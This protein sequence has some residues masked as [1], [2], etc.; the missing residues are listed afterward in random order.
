MRLREILISAQSFGYGPA[1]KAVAIASQ[2]RKSAS[3]VKLTFLGNRNA[4]H[5]AEC[6]MSVFD[7]II[8]TKNPREIGT[9]LDR[10]NYAQIISVMEPYTSVLGRNRYIPIAYV[11]SLYFF[12]K[13]KS[14]LSTGEITNIRRLLP[15]NDE[16]CLK[17]LA[18]LNSHEMQLAG[19][20]AADQSFIQ[21]YPGFVRNDISPD[22]IGTLV[23]VNPILEDSTDDFADKDT[24]LVSLCGQISPAIDLEKAL[25]YAK[26]CLKLITPCVT[27]LPHGITTVIVGNPDVIRHLR[28]YT[29]IETTNLSHQQYMNRLK[30]SVGLLAPVSLTSLYES[31]SSQ[32]PVFFLPEQHDGHAPNYINLCHHGKSVSYVEKTFPGALLFKRFPELQDIA[33]NGVGTIYSIIRELETWD[34]YRYFDEGMKSLNTALESFCHEENSRL[35]AHAQRE[36]LGF[37]DDEQFDG[38]RTIVERIL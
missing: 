2:I 24:L 5:F 21:R 15:V 10:S 14:I 37:G 34:R 11:D 36:T 33:E 28:H 25:S 30:K 13:W 3:N 17:F 32:V 31:V 12:W 7:I 16:Q 22:E 18:T 20:V 8:E 27:Q 9:H 23:S 6:N 4:V 35:L 19:H 38:A 1:S 26:L 29:D